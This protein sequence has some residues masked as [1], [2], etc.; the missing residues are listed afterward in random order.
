[1]RHDGL[2][3]LTWSYVAHNHGAGPAVVTF[4]DGTQVTTRPNTWALAT[5]ETALPLYLPRISRGQ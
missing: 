4:S 3:K 2:G 1:V 5:R